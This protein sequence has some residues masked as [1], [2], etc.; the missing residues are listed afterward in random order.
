[1]VML[2]MIIMLLKAA[3][4]V[5]VRLGLKPALGPAAS[6][7]TPQVSLGDDHSSP[8]ETCGG[9]RRPVASQRPRRAL[10]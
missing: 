3:T 4:V 8:N 7:M 9:R 1:M 6:L 2:I 5:Q 10:G